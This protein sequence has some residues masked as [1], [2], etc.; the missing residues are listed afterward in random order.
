MKWDVSVCVGGGGGGVL[1]SQVLSLDN[2][3]SERVLVVML[4][5]STKSCTF[6]YHFHT[7]ILRD[8]N[9]TLVFSDII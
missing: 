5:G 7:Y 6:R 8:G 2:G 9:S 4:K 1:A 3:V